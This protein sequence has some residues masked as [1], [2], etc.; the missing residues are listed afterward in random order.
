MKIY[1]RSLPMP[2][3]LAAHGFATRM[4]HSHAHLFCILP[5]EFLS[6]KETACSLD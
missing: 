4:S 3:L 1:F 5:N 6:K 2:V